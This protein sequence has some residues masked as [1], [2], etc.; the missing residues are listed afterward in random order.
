MIRKLTPH[1][2]PLGK[3]DKATWVQDIQRRARVEIGGHRGLGL[4]LCGL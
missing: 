2:D 4:V 3:P 1:A